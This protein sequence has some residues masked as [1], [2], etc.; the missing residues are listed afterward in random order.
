MKKRFAMVVAGS[1]VAALLAGSAAL[2]LGLLGASTASAGADRSAP[3]VRTIERTVTIHKKQKAQAGV[4]YVIASAPGASSAAGSESESESEHE[5]E[6][7]EASS[8]SDDGSY[9]SQGSGGYEDD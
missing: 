9:G 6:S 2:S 1:L 7:D 4:R 8:G 5:F 3:R